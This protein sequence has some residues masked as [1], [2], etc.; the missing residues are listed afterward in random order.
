MSGI[1]NNKDVEIIIR[2]LDIGAEY[3]KADKPTRIRNLSIMYEDRRAPRKSTRRNT[4]KKGVNKKAN[5]YW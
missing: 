1:E 2:I 3:K 5:R 4:R